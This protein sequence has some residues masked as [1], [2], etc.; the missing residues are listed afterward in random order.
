MNDLTNRIEPI[1]RMRGGVSYTSEEHRDF[2]D[3]MEAKGLDVE[4]YHDRSF[5]I[6]PCVRVDKLEEATEATL[7]QCG[8]QSIAFDG[9]DTEGYIVYPCRS[10]KRLWRDFKKWRSR[11]K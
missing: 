10:D 8:H 11:S 2:I 4:L 1:G 6:G 3:D 7:V 5:Y 9:R